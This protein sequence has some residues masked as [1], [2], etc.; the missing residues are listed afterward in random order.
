MYP[1][2]LF[3]RIWVWIMDGWCKKDA[4]F[5]VYDLMAAAVHMLIN[6]SLFCQLSSCLW[7]LLSQKINILDLLS[8]VVNFVVVDVISPIATRESHYWIFRYLWYHLKV[9]FYHFITTN[10]TTNTTT[11]TT[12]TT[13]KARDVF[14][15]TLNQQLA[16][17]RALINYNY[18]PYQEQ[19]HSTGQ[20]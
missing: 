9:S 14:E 17:L 7:L 12:T 6:C 13:S 20:T 2:L 10:T 18:Q 3:H 19:Q 11:T 8:L 4:L 1:F 15:A 16:F 5:W